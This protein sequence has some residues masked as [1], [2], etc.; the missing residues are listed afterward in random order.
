MKKSINTD[1]G[2]IR[3]VNNEN[4]TRDKLEMKKRTKYLRNEIN[5]KLLT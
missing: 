2:E 4:I 1:S 5:P 3:G